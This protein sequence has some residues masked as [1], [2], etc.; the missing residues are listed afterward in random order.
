[1]LP[2]LAVVRQGGVHLPRAEPAVAG[3]GHRGVYLRSAGADAQPR[4]HR[5]GVCGRGRRRAVGLYK[6]N[7]VDP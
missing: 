7:P 3:G 1:M 5:G 6:L 2:T 4:R